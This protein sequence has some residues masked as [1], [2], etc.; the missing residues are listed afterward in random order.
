M[1]NE[2]LFPKSYQKNPFM[3]YN[4]I[5][6]CE[7][8]LDHSLLKATITP[9]SKNP[10]GMLHGGLIYTMLDCVAGITARA[11]GNDY[12]TQNVY[13]NYMSNVN[14]QPEIYAESEVIKRGKTVTV[15]HALVRTPSGQILATAEV[16][17]FRVEIE[18]KA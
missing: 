14:N 6:I 3:D 10:Y 2:K 11:D 15:V 12:V 16:N 18:S 1:S 7:V 4:H 17:M 13:V 8:S 9:E 5:E